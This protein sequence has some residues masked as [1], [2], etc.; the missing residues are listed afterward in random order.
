[1]TRGQNANR[2]HV[3]AADLDDAREQFAAALER[4]RADRGLTAATQA[5]REAVAGL[6][7]DGPVRLVNAERARLTER[8]E[9]ADQQAEKWGR[10]IAALIRQR[11]AHRAESDDQQ[12]AV[13]AADSRAA[14]MRAEVAAPLIEQAT[15]DGVAYIEA[16]ERMWKAQAARGQ[17]GRLRKRAVDRAATQAVGE[18]HATEDTVRRRGGGL[19]N[20]ASGVQPWAEAVAGKQADADPRVTETR[21]EAEQTHRQQHRLAERH[22]QESAALHRQALGSTTPSTA[23][24]RAAG[25][26]TRAEQARRDLAE[27][28]ALPVTEA[29]RL[30]RERAARAEAE[31]EAAERAQAARDAR[32]AQLGQFRPSS[33]HGWTGPEH[34]FGPSL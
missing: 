20:G 15:A 22:L 34:N 3:V 1:M 27:I 9:H 14:Q 28:E 2:L 11:D 13:A 21:Q 17:A 7:A 33:D 18:H 29:A 6:A 4:D 31:R 24:T 12:E 32:A 8:I 30:V 19:P 26:R 5:A 25:W 16:R 23:S 10:A